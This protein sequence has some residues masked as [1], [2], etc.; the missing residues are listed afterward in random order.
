VKSRCS[1]REFIRNAGE[2]ALKASPSGFELTAKRL[3][4]A[5]NLGAAAA[6]SSVTPTEPPNTESV[7]GS[8][9]VEQPS[10]DAVQAREIAN[11]VGQAT[12]PGLNLDMVLLVK[13][14]FLVVLN[15]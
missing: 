6:K 3:E 15:Q 12:Q 2:F 8:G 10:L 1:I 14:G 7:T 5:A 13:S 4:A 9:G 11:V